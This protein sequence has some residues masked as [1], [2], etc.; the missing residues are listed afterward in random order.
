MDSKSGQHD[1]LRKNAEATPA[2]KQSSTEIKSRSAEEFLHELS[3]HHIELEMQNEELRRAQCAIEAMR[4][5]YVDLYEFAPVGY[6]TLNCNGMIT[7]VN[8]TGAEMLGEERKKLLNRSFAH[9]I[10]PKDSDQWDHHFLSVLR[11]NGRQSCELDIQRSDGSGFYAKVASLKSGDSLSSTLSDDSPLSN[12]IPSNS[13]QLR[14]VI[15]DIS[16]I[17]LIEKMLWEKNQLLDNIVE[18]IPNMIFLKRASDLSF[19]MFNKAGENLLGYS[20]HDLLGKGD[21]DFWP[22]EQAD[23]F[24]AEDRKTLASVNNTEIAEEPIRC[25]NGEIRYLHTWKVALRDAGGE[26]THL[27]GI[28]VDI[29]ERK[30]LADA[31]IARDRDFR[32]L[33]DAMPQIVWISLPGGENIYTNQ[34]WIN[35]TGLSFGESYGHGWFKSFHPEDAPVALNIFQSTAANNGAYSLEFKLRRADGEYRWWLFRG[36]PVLD[37]A[38][39]ISKWFGTCTD[40]NDIKQTEHELR[41]AAIN[42]REITAK[43]NQLTQE[44]SRRNSDL[45]ALTAHIQKVAE[46]ERASLA[47]ELHDEM[48]SILTGLSMEIGRLGEEVSDPDILQ[49]FST[50]KDLISS[51]SNIKQNIINQ[52]YPTILEDCGF[53]PAV[54]WLVKEYRRYSGITVELVIPKEAIVIEHPFALAA[55]R[56]IQECL[57]NIAKHAG[58]SKVYIEVA[59]KD[60]F[61]DLTIRDNGKGLPDDIKTGGHGIFGMIERARYLGGLMEVVSDEEKG[62]TA[63]LSIPL[64]TAK[65]KIKKRVLVVDDHAIVR[66]A[67]Q[68]LLDTQTDDFSVEGEAA[69]GKSAIQMAIEGTWDI[70]LLDINLPKKNGVKVLEEIKA[71]KPGLPIIML[72]SHA[73]EEYGEIALAKGAA[74]YIEKSETTKL[75]EAMRRAT[76]L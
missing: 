49:G 35:Y 20:R 37:G 65:P 54:S 74:G 29:T 51:A 67:L 40:I 17:K 63:R 59:A 7:E 76:I 16:K 23:G 39:N 18:N 52:L 60:G 38:G 26:P 69:D 6:L 11:R 31:L 34:Q 61:L 5:R 43:N 12:D 73:E 44:I 24:V 9:F 19:E 22:K 33:A 13:L 57:T 32:L 62:A 25:A 21:Y 1:F 71:L 48:G 58:A 72:S 47:R 28:S 3:A 70:M 53:V 27:L 36:V 56:I 42:E 15:T 10:N 2:Y 50:I 64:V 46:T 45:S 4:D 14:I 8:L 41:V 66:N 30:N 55:Y 75:V 68:Q